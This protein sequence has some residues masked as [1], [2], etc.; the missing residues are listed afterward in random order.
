MQ[1]SLL[2]PGFFI[3][4]KVSAVAGFFAAGALIVALIYKGF[5]KVFGEDEVKNTAGFLL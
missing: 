5:K 2:P 1:N 4:I 3:F